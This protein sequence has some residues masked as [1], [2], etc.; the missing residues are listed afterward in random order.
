MSKVL[1]TRSKLDTLA[2]TI[3]QKSGVAVPLTLDEMNTA[4]GNINPGSGG[5]TQDANGY[6]VLPSTGGG[7]GGGATAHGIHLEFSDSTDTD[8]D[9]YYDDSVLG[10]M[11]TAYKPSTWTYSN[12]TVVSAALDNT[13]WYSVPQGTWTTML[14]LSNVQWNASSDPYPYCWITSL[15]SVYPAAGEIWRVTWAGIE[16]ICT[17]QS[18]TG[19][20][21]VCIGN[22]KYVERADD[23][24]DVP[25]CFVNANYGAWVGGAD[26]LA[27]SQIPTKLEKLLTS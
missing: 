3:S 6:I 27:N 19:Y 21:Y 10:T 8:I 12:K 15:S 20:N 22:P 5:V 23:G 24:T 14:S 13:T 26:V 2:N 1:I 4:V 11:I 9:V 17:A 18:V 16:Y 25:F 7:G